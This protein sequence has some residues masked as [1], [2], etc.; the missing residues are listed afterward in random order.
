[1]PFWEIGS[2]FIA[3]PVYH[4]VLNNDQRKEVDKW[5]NKFGS[6]LD[7]KVPT[8]AEL[9]AEIGDVTGINDIQKAI[10]EAADGFVRG[11]WILVACGVG[12]VILYLFLKYYHHEQPSHAVSVPVAVPV[13]GG[14]AN[15]AGPTVDAVPVVP[16]RASRLKA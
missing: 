3:S 11:F 10:K 16:V 8:V 2:P 14:V 4:Y 6:P 5:L 13:M 9:K 7:V 12:I 1:M 15:I